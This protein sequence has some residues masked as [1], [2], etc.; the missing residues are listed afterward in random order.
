MP[1]PRM[2]ATPTRSLRLAAAALAL[3]LLL[4]GCGSKGALY[5][6]EDDPKARTDAGS[7]K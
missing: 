6:P 3:F 4:A 5:L 7:K 2:T 1:P